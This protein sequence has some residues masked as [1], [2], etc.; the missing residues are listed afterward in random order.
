[1]MRVEMVKEVK[2]KTI[3]YTKADMWDRKFISDRVD[4]YQ[5]ER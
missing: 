4:A 5:N 2:V 3:D 1:M